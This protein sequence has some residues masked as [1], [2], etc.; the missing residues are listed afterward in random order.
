MILE[1]VGINSSASTL[2]KEWNQ[3]AVPAANVQDRV[4]RSRLNVLIHENLA[5]VICI[6]EQ[7]IYFVE[8]RPGEDRPIAFNHCGSLSK[9]LLDPKHGILASKGDFG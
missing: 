9:R 5:T 3:I 1:L 8:M 2:R 7:L 4:I 6:N